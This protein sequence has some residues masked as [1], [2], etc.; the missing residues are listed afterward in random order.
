[1]V[2]RNDSISV[3]VN[4]P[5]LSLVSISGK[6]YTEKILNNLEIMFAEVVLFKISTNSKVKFLSKV[7]P[8]GNRPHKS[9]ATDNHSDTGIGTGIIGAGW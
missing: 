7:S 8:V 2:L 6:P 4:Y 3:D 5:P 9:T 1:M